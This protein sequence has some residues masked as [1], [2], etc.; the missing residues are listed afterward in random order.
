MVKYLLSIVVPAYNESENLVQTCDDIISAIPIN[1]T[2][3]IVVIDDGSTDST[4]EIMHK[5]NSKN[6]KIKLIALSRNFGK[7]IAT[8][9][10][11]N[12]TKGDVTLILDADGQHPPELIPEFLAKWE[13][14]SKVVIGVRESNVKEGFIKKYGSKIFYVLLNKIA[15]V[16]MVPSSTDFRLIDKEVSEAFKTMKESNRITRGL[17]DWLGYSPVYLTF[18]A[19]E[20][21]HGEA[22]YSTKK[23]IKLALNSVVSL[24]LLPLYISSYTGIFISTL[25]AIIGAV[26]LIENYILS[27]PLGWDITGSASLGILIVFL[28]GVLLMSQG[29]IALYISRIYEESRGRPLYAI[30]KSRS[31]L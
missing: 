16:K 9:A 31:L 26:V 1:Y 12:S 28:V 25:S 13:A 2:Y 18:H 6:K 17:I 5:I 14:G 21:I 10:G 4:V 24:S 29:L 19:K 23:L 30:N 8:T 22:G 7:E 20:R 15:G 3:E 11:I 27:D